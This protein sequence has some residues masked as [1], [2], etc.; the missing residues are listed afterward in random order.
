L[1]R[2]TLVGLGVLAGKG[3]A[4]KEVLQMSTYVVAVCNRKRV[5]EYS[6]NEDAQ[7]LT[8]TWQVN[9]ETDIIA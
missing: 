4:L 7:T 5:T 8:F 2:E 3:K 6:G 1:R 9:C